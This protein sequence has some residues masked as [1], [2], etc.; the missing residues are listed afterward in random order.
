MLDKFSPI[1][2][3]NQSDN[4]GKWVTS[5]PRK[6]SK[7]TKNN[8]KDRDKEV[9]AIFLELSGEAESMPQLYFGQWLYGYPWGLWWWF[10]FDVKV[11]FSLKN[12]EY[13]DNFQST[14]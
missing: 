13:F 12:T 1:K 8:D 14:F 10:L 7:K 4:Q 9:D 6:P 2:G 3:K 11:D 5:T